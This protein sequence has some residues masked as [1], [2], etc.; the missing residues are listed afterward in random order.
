M[1]SVIR[2]LVV[3]VGADL[4]EFQ[5]NMKQ[6]SKDMKKV[7]KELSAAGSTLTKGLT[8]PIL[9]A[10]AGLTGLAIN[11][12]KDADAL[13]TLANKTGITTQALQE[14]QYAARFIDVEVET[15]TGSMQ[16]LTKNMDMA[17][18]GSKDQEEAFKR[19]G[20]EYKN[21]DGSLRN[22]KDVWAESIDALGKVASEADRDALAMNLFGKS[23]AEL[24]PLIKVGST[25]L[26]RYAQ[27]AHDVGAVMDDKTVSALGRFDD[28]MQRIQAVLKN[29]TAEI[30]AAFLPVLEKLTPVF[31]E[32]IVPAIQSLAGFIT[33]LIEKFDNMS[34]EMQG[35]VVGLA[36]LAVAIGPVIHIIGIVIT[37][38]S[39]ITA[40]FAAASAAIAGGGGIIAALGALLGPVGIVLVVIA[41]LAA[42]AYLIIK[43]WE[44]I[45][46]FFINLWT[47]VTDWIVT[48]WDNI[49]NF[50]TTT[51]E[52]LKTFF[53]TWG[54]EMLAIIL[55]FIGIPLLIIK[56]WDEIKA[57]L[58]SLWNGIAEFFT[59][60]IP[61]IID[62]IVKFF[63][64]LPGKI[65]Y[66]LGFAIGTLIKWGA[67]VV[68]WVIENVPKII[69]SAVNFFTEL[70]EKLAAILVSVLETVFKW[71]TDL[72][73]WIAKEVP[74]FIE[75]ISN[76]FK[77]IPDKIWSVFTKVMDKFGEFV[78]NVYTWAK[79]KLP[80][81]VN[82]IVDFFLGLP[83]KMLDV[84]KNIV[85]GI[86]NGINNTVSWL[87]DKI[88]DFASGIV[89]G[90][91]DALDIHSPSGVMAEQVG[92]WIP[93]GISKGILDN[94]RLVDAAMANLS[95]DMN[96]NATMAG[97]TTTR[98]NVI[99]LN[100]TGNTISNDYDVDRLMERAVK[101]LR[102][103][104][105]MA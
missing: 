26:K 19:L 48:A 96:I 90:I 84:G 18:K 35:F 87:K 76:F 102:M 93:A 31:E 71:G 57:F 86:W 8:L 47:S 25:E 58:I 80:G 92:K 7:G 28:T 85:E 21:Q 101:R 41:A 3:K 65:G 29:A 24:N 51:W 39:G 67:D 50:F 33:G 99:N 45:K 68:D 79:E 1:S 5:K 91:K 83:G 94:K 55:P 37:A 82:N 11:A 97:Q 16:K 98:G 100:I 2:S 72:G 34:P 81:V 46:E 64:E 12:G 54:T 38:I 10:V 60:K 27:E 14:M 6:V 52:N 53:A 13:I 62:N 74:K 103:E 32:K 49:K 95:T 20:V 30:G 88:R 4:T 61:E 56:H 40:G 77:E 9:G 105:L 73:A 104:G 89:R 44:P 23:S 70:P 63:N 78:S 66:A 42:A 75:N 69:E 17:R 22:A 36:G 43:N 59:T 15:M